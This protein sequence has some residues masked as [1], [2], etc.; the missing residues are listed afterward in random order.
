MTPEDEASKTAPAGGETP[1]PIPL[2]PEFPVTWEDPELEQRLW[3]EDRMHFPEPVTPLMD[4]FA[5][6]FSTGFERA[7]QASHVPIRIESRSFNTYFY[8]SV[9]PMAPP[10]EMEARGK[11]AQTKLAEDMGRLQEWWETELLPEVLEHMA[12]WEG[13]D[14]RGASMPDLLSHLDDT[15]ERLAR[16]WDIHFLVGFPFLLA[17]SMF[18]DMYHDL[19]G[20]EGALDAYRLL[21]GYGNRTVDAG[22]ELWT[23]SRTALASAPV[24]EALAA[25]EPA[26]VPQALRGFPE[27]KAFLADLDVYLE[28]YGQR[29]DVFAEIGYP[30]WIEDPRTPIK[31]LKDFI[32]Q[33]ER[34]LAAELAELAAERERLTGEARERLKGY[35][36]PVRGQFEFFLKAARAAAVVQE[37]HNFWIDQRGTYK[38]RRVMQEFGRRFAEAGVIDEREDVFY[39]VE[40]ELRETAGESPQQ[41][42]RGLVAERKARMDHFRTIRPPAAIGTPPAGAP[43][44]DPLSLAFA[45]FFGPPPEPSSD[46]KVVNG[47]PGSPGKARG[48]AKVVANLAEAGKLEPGDI[49]VAPATMPPWTPL[50][51]T[52]A[53]VV[54]D[55]G[56]ALSHA[57]IVARE[58]NIPAVLGTGNATSVIKDGQTL[59][60]DGDAGV[61]RIVS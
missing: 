46:P 2:P 11:L 3:V 42:R 61:V 8:N 22:H 24:R 20:E 60:V 59:E 26:D 53:A 51:A 16:L 34:D 6:A 31:N 25:H 1:T 50:F 5:R 36:E 17:P 54:T 37:D 48:T 9:V 23:L 56:G 18:N 44:S 19:F 4:A 52:V 41:D 55:A 49:L 15:L 43:P 40:A 38:V 12:F 35:P 10:E 14:L 33:P 29:S 39:L 47:N 45:R 32:T 13:F 57:A 27:G 58:Y 21:Q 28:E 30:H 7:A